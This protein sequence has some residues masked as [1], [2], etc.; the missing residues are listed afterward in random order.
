MKEEKYVFA[1]FEYN[2]QPVMETIQFGVVITDTSCNIEDT[3]NV[4]VK[5][6]QPVTEYVEHL[7]GI[8]NK[9]LTN[10]S[11]FQAV[12]TSFIQ[13][14][15]DHEG[16]YTFYAWGEDWKQLRREARKCDMMKEYDRIIS[17]KNRVNYQRIFS[18]KTLYQGQLMT[19]SI[20]LE[21]AKALYGLPYHVEHDA[22][23]DAKDTMEIYK[24]V[25]VE[26]KI[27]DENELKRIFDEKQKHIKHMKESK[28]KQTRNMFLPLFPLLSSF[29]NIAI[30]NS[31]FKYLKSG[32]GAFF[33]EIMADIGDEKVFSRKMCCN[34]EENSVEIDVKMLDEDPILVFFNVYQDGKIIGT[35]KFEITD[36]NRRFVVKFL[37]KFVTVMENE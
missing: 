27:Y 26:K 19:K 28:D 2:G 22:L 31:V 23:S 15:E 29:Q 12:F 8:T 35:H 14:L 11:D 36:E 5:P 10:A 3:F 20:S 24:K 30:D 18:R 21:D 37:K 34:Y 32:S 16:S 7:T 17:E 6:Q 13:W 9:D 1:D 4:L 25:E 33:N